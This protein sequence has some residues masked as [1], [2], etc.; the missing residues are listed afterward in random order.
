MR[1]RGD[2]P[3]RGQGRPKSGA[4]DTNQPKPKP[5]EPPAAPKR[6]VSSAWA[7]LSVTMD[8]AP[9]KPEPKPQV[10]K[11]EPKP[12]DPPQSK[13]DQPKQEQPKPEPPA[14]IPEQP[15]EEPVKTTP[16]ES[17]T[18]LFIPKNTTTVKLRAGQFGTLSGPVTKPE[19]PKR[20]NSITPCTTIH[21]TMGPE[22]STPSPPPNMP[23]P[24]MCPMWGMPIPAEMPPGMP[25][26]NVL[27]WYQYQYY[28]QYL[29]WQYAND[30]QQKQK[31]ENEEPPKE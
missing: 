21:I 4:R 1:R 9:P 14:E 12:Q 27:A 24:D 17:E 30:Q 22:P 2:R 20:A 6:P 3:A 25:P 13:P 15:H 28:C 31:Q 19:S 26:P 5:E 16:K 18:R 7:N 23:P 29:Q 8:G 10:T 11:P